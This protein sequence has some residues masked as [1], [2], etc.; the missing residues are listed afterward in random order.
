MPI[1]QEDLGSAYHAE[2]D[3][4][5]PITVGT[6]LL[7]VVTVVACLGLATAFLVAVSYSPFIYFRF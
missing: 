5:E 3:P 4:P 7:M 1:A 6:S 2:A